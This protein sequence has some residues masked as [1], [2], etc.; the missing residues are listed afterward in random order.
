MRAYEYQILNGI[1][2]SVLRHLRPFF[3][4]S[5]AVTAR[6]VVSQDARAALESIEFESA[7]QR[8]AEFLIA[9]AELRARGDRA[10]RRVRSDRTFTCMDCART[11]RG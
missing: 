8:G 4:Q 2:K 11:S 6:P 10:V 5:G 3:E 7:D 1:V 9:I